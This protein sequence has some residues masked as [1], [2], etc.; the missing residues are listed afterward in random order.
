MVLHLAQRLDIPLRERN[1][2]LLA[3]GYAPGFS[4]R[5]L[6]ERDMTPVR[7]A[8]DRLLKAHE[9]YPALVVD[10]H[11]NIIAANL[12]VQVVV[13]GVAAELLAPPANALRIA[14][15]PAGLAPRIR[16]LG[17]WS[18]HLLAR[19]QREM[20]VAPD[21]E[22]ND[23]YAELAAYPGVETTPD[24]GNLEAENIM[25]MHSLHLDDANLTLFST[26]TTF[27][28]AR[29]ITLAE[30]TI[31]SFYPADAETAEALTIGVAE[32]A[33]TGS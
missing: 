12:G 32:L 11:W 31:E 13:R 8:L 26:V 1:H 22:L 2:L 23:L 5:S 21:Q 3:A 9:P 16:N 30:L 14:L 18:N 10:R 4:E 28:T 6:D 24:P 15:H 17:E 20:E 19:L 29:D 25:L 33:A 27:G 7:D